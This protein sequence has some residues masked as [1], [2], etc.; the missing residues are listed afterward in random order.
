[1]GSTRVKKGIVGLEVTGLGSVMA[2]GKSMAGGFAKAGLV[3]DGVKKSIALVKDAYLSAMEVLKG[4][5]FDEGIDRSFKALVGGADDGVIALTE[6]RNATRGLVSDTDLQV[7][8]SRI[9]GTGLELA[10]DKMGDL[11]N[12]TIATGRAMGKTATESVHLLTQAFQRN[13]PRALKMISLSIDFE[14]AQQRVAKSLGIT[15][16]EM[17]EAQKRQILLEETMKALGKAGDELGELDTPIGDAFDRIEATFANMGSRINEILTQNPAF[18]RAMENIADIVVKVATAVAK[19]VSFFQPL[20][21]LFSELIPLI[22]TV[23]GGL[24]GFFASGGNPL[25]A[26]AGG[27]A[28]GSLFAFGDDPLRADPSKVRSVGD[29][30]ERLARESGRTHSESFY[31]QLSEDLDGRSTRIGM[32]RY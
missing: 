10:T 27:A 11:F 13:N 14:Q 6:L 28:A 1:M 9:L 5:A 30:F 15:T 24:A 29:S 3:I 23:G 17:G 16:T 26:A 22:A 12:A 2:A 20:I 32:E 4:A 31:N 8:A 18:I 21:E 7:A 25:G 19:L